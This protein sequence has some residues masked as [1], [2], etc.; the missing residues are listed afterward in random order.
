MS[1]FRFEHVTKRNTDGHRECAVLD[2][3]SFEIDAGDFIGIW[4]KRRSG[5]STLLRIAAGFEL[6]D[7]GRILFD[8]HDLTALSS[9]E[10]AGLLRIGGIGFVASDWRP[11]VSQETIEYVALPL[12]ANK[13]SLRRAR[14]VAQEWLEQMGVANCAHVLT[15]R[16]SIGE[17][18]RVGLAHALAREPRLLLI[19][20]PEALPSPSERDDLRVTLRS[21]GKSSDLALVIASEDLGAVAYSRRTMTLGSGSLHSTDKDAEVISLPVGRR[22]E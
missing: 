10:R 5:K 8:G 14:R 16:L 9:D 3:V 22:P 17:A 2:D 4:G 19:D 1:F 7:E 21:L 20:E 18:M 6:P 13:L 11:I 15:E 12:L